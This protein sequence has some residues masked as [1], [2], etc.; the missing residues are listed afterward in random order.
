MR[1]AGRARLGPCLL[2]LFSLA[3]GR[4][5]S[6]SEAVVL[7][8]EPAPPAEK[9]PCPPHQ[10]EAATAELSADALVAE[11]LARNPSLAQMTAAWQAASARYPQ[12]T[13]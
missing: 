9:A 11:V 5:R 2:L 4:A 1:P 13:P 3:A 10:P 12:V 8:P 7:Q 6:A